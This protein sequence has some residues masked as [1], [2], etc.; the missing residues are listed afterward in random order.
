LCDFGSAF[1]VNENSITEYL[2]SRYY[3]APEIMLGCPYDTAIDV[4][5]SACTVYELYTGQFLFPG[6]NNNEMLK[7]IMQT[8]GKFNNK[9]L[10]RGEFT[11]KYFDAQNNFL[12]KEADPIT[13]M[14]YYKS[15][16]IPDKPTRSIEFL[17]AGVP[18]APEEQK[19]VNSLKDFLEKCLALDPKNRITPEDAIKHP[20]LHTPVQS[21]SQTQ[22]KPVPETKTLK[23]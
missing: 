1:P 20:F 16:T 23:F 11:P 9:I 2:V 4:W 5:S 10:K 22:N 21:Q 3:R 12:S 7:L 18:A 13:K 6:K 19:K 14:E 17:L 15:I 8:K